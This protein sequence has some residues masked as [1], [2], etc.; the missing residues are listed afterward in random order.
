MGKAII[1][2]SVTI[3]VV[4]HSF[5]EITTEILRATEVTAKICL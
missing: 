4:S 5:S 2:Q 3:R 1:F